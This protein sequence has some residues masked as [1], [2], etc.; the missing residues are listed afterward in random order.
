MQPFK[1]RAT[2]FTTSPEPW[3]SD[4]IEKAKLV[5]GKVSNL[6][7]SYLEVIKINPDALIKPGV[8][9]KSDGKRMFA[10][11]WFKQAITSMTKTSNIVGFHCSNAERER[12]GVTAFNGAYWTDNDP[13]VEFWF[14]ADRNQPSSS[15]ATKFIT[16]NGT[17]LA[18][19]QWLR[20]FLHEVGHGLVH[21]SGRFKELI[22]KLG[23]KTTDRAQVVHHLDYERKDIG[24]LFEILDFKPWSQ[25][26]FIISLLNQVAALLKLKAAL[27]TP[28]PKPPTTQPRLSQWAK[29][30]EKFEDY[31]VPG[32][33]YR[34]GTP[35]PQGSLSYRNRNPGNLRWSPLQTGER[36][37]FS[38]FD[39]YEIGF[40]ALKHQL[41]IAASGRSRVYKPTMSILQFFEVYAPSGDNN[42]PQTYAKFV[43]N[44]L[45]VSVDT[46][47]S[48]LL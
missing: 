23:L 29:A 8:V 37:G 44:E 13:V 26:V 28:K 2:I 47:I 35:A 5:L 1:V 42:H 27:P 32:G 40:E 12:W 20:L 41:N 45:G 46:P 21:H 43:A 3:Y 4:D 38:Y 39:T 10:H 14:A 17:K 25:Q 9:T 34:G 18:M 7:I 31:V 36:G 15:F 16:I 6:Q 33:T 48:S 19:T 24:Y 22:A 11:A 30:I